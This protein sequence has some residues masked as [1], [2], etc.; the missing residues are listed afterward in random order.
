MPSKMSPIPLIIS[1]GPSPQESRAITPEEI[2]IVPSEEGLGRNAGSEKIVENSEEER[3]DHL[4]AA[5]A[6]G[7]AEVGLDVLA[8]GAAVK[9]AAQELID[10]PCQTRRKSRK[11]ETKVGDICIK[12]DQVLYVNFGHKY[13]PARIIKIDPELCGA[14]NGREIKFRFFDEEKIRCIGINDFNFREEYNPISGGKPLRINRVNA[15][16]IQ[17]CYQDEFEEGLG[18]SL[19]VKNMNFL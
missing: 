13:Y 11:R 9:R 17:K 3:F 16:S 15:E 1:I 10:S 14:E 19:F 6:A 2:P 7:A 12:V 8:A 5:G 18:K 4:V